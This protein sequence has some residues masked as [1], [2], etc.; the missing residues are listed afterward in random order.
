MYDDE[1]DDFP[2][3][4]IK[5]EHDRLV[6]A[7]EAVQAQPDGGAV[8]E[9]R[10]LPY[11][12][13]VCNRHTTD[14][15]QMTPR[16]D[17]GS[18]GIMVTLPEIRPHL[19]AVLTMGEPRVELVGLLDDEGRV[20]DA[21]IEWQLDWGAEGGHYGGGSPALISVAQFLKDG[22]SGSDPRDFDF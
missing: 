7:W 1:F 4:A 21:R 22:L 18:T 14:P 15:F 8:A 13:G 17:A 3:F 6:E 9:L 11:R 5:R 19:C 12:T 2:M 16:S 20:I 10:E